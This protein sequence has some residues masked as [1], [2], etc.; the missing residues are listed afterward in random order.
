MIKTGADFDGR[1]EKHD[2]DMVEVV[3]NPVPVEEGGFRP[4]ARFFLKEWDAMKKRHA[5]DIGMVVQHTKTGEI[6]RVKGQLQLC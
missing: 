4:G 2:Y 3:A 5:V 1:F 6:E